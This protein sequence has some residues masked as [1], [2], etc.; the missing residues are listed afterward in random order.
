MCSRLFVA[1]L[2]VL[3]LLTTHAQAVNCAVTPNM[4]SCTCS[5]LGAT[6]IASDKSTVV[7]CFLETGN[8]AASTCS[9]GGGCVWKGMYGS[10]ASTP[11]S[12]TLM[13][14][15]IEFTQTGACV[16]FN[17]YLKA[18]ATCGSTCMCPAGYEKVSIGVGYMTLYTSHYAC[19]V[20]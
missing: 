4:D 6:Q 11:V 7:G 18:P 10:A 20:R 19:M 13:G 16:V 8:T 12:G 17:H 1:I 3:L 9:A 15:C 14:V 2:T 5:T